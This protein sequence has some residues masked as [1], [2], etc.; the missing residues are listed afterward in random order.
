MAR[1]QSKLQILNA[2]VN[3]IVDNR[4]KDIINP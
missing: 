4:Q 3:D 2:K 1:F